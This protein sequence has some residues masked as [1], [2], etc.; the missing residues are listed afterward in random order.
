MMHRYWG[1]AMPDYAD[2]YDYVA[3]EV[4]SGFIMAAMDYADRQFGRIRK[5][6]AAN[7]RS[8]LVVAASMGQG[9]VGKR[10]IDRGLFVLEDHDLLVS[11]LGL[12]AAEFGLA[13]YPC[14]SL[15]FPDE[16]AAQEA[17]A[18]LESVIAEGGHRLFYEG[19]CRLEGKTVTTVIDNGYDTEN[20]Q[21]A[22]STRLRFRP[23]GAD[24]DV[25]GTPADLGFTVR[26]RIGGDNTAYHI[27][28]GM[29][30]AYG[31]GV[32]PDPSRKEV[33]VLDVAPSLLANV[34]G[35]EPAPS[36]QGIPSLF[37]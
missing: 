34:L 16:A 32:T 9:P 5:Y 19:S 29:M 8:M 27:P 13:M 20:A 14:L 35:V 28:E 6:I 31:A 30:L 1:D 36:M 4:Y 33:D 26:T 10:F 7:P 15:V 23:L 2:S 21:P 37:A 25:I 18:P 11:R 24:C 17:V 12:K 22:L 3:D